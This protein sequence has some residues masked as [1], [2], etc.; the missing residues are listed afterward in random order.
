MAGKWRYFVAF[1]GALMIFQAGFSEPAFVRAQEPSPSPI[2]SPA[3]PSEPDP[4]SEPAPT[5]SPTA[6]DDGSAAPPDEQ[7]VDGSID[8]PGVERTDLRTASSR[9]FEQ[10][11]GTFVSQFFSDS[12]FYQPDGSDQWQPIDL[13]LRPTS[14]EDASLAVETAPV[15]TLLFPAVGQD[16]FL[17]IEGAGH[18]I[19]LARWDEDSAADP[20]ATQPVSQESGLFADYP[21]F[22]PGGVSLRVFPR[23]DGFKTFIVLPARPEINSFSLRLDVPGLTVVDNKDGSFSLL[24]E[25]GQVVGELPRPF[26][27][28][29]SVLETP[30]GDGRGGGVYSEAV[31]QTVVEEGESWR[32][33]LTIDPAFLESAVYPVYVD[34]TTTT[35]PTGST[36][37]SDTFANSQAPNTNFN[38]YQRPDS[39]FYH[40]QWH[41]NTPDTSYFNEVYIRFNDLE[42]TLGAGLIESAYLQMYPYWQYYH[43]D[44]RKSW[45]ERVSADWAA[46]TLKWNNRPATDLTIGEFTS[47]EDVWT[48]W[49]LKTFVQDVVNGTAPNY[50][51]MIHANSL[52]NGGWKRFVSRNDSSNLKPK[53]VVTW[54]AFAG[55]SVFYPNSATGETSTRTMQWTLPTSSAQ[56]AYEAQ[57]A[58]NSTFTTGLVTSGTVTSSI[59]A[60]HI[61][62][63]TS[64]TDGQLYYWR[65]KVKYGNNTSFTAWSD[66]GSFVYRQG[67]TLGLADHN[68]FESFALGNGDQA[69]VNVSTGNLVIS[70]PIVGLTTR[71]G[72]FDLALFYNS[73]S[74]VNAGAG[75]GWRLNAMRRL[76]ELGNGNVVFTAGDGS[77]HTFTKIST[78]GTVTTY[79]RP[80]TVYGTLRKDTANALEWTLTYRDL[81]VDSFDVFGSEGLLAKQADRHGNAITFSY[82]SGTNRLSQATDPN[83]RV[84]DFAWNTGVSPARLSSITDWAYVSSGVVQSSATGSRRQYRFFY[85]ANGQLIGWSNPVNTSGSCPTQAS[86]LTCLTYDANNGLL[87]T[88]SKTQTYTTFAVTTHPQGVLGTSS[89]T[90][91]TSIT[92]RGGEVAEIRDAEQTAASTTGTTITRT[93][94]TEVQVVRQGTPASTTTYVLVAT[95]DPHGRVQSIKRLLGATNIEQ[96]IVWDSTYPTEPASVTD[97]YG[98]LLSTPARTVSYTYVASSM[99]LVSVMTEPLT[100]STNRTTT[101]TYN[102][103]NDVTQVVVASGASS[104]TTRY[105]YTTSGCSTSATDL[106]LRSVIDNYVDGTKGGGSGNEQDVTTDYLY[107]ANGQRTRETRWNYDASGNLL[108]SRATG[109]TWDANGNQTSVIGNY[110]DGDTAD[111]Y[112][113]DPDPATGARTDLT[114]G[115]TYDTAGNQISSADPRRAL[116]SGLHADDYVTRSEFDALNRQT[117][118]TAPRDPADTSAPK[119]AT[120]TYDELGG[121]RQSTDFGGSIAASTYDRA[122]RPVKTYEDADGA[123]SGPAEITG[124][125]TYDAAGRITSQKDRNQIGNASLGTTLNVYDELSRLVDKTEAQGSSPDVSS[126]TR[127]VFDA[128]DRQIS[129]TVGY[130]DPVAQTTTTSYDLGGRATSVDDGFACTAS[131]YNFRD[132][133]ITETTGLAGTTCATDSDTQTIT[134]TYDGLGRLTR[135]AVTAGADTGDWTFDATLDGAGS[136]LTSAVKTGGV[137]STTTY[138]LSP[139]NQTS[140]ENR[141]DGS[142]NKTNYDA[143]GNPTDRCYWKSGI[144]VGECLAEGSGGWSNPPTQ[145]TTTTYDARNNR[146]EL[147]DSVL[148]T[149]TT[150]D[151]DHNYAIKAFYVKTSGGRE[152]QTLYLYDD[153]HRPTSITHQLC[154]VSSG[155][156]CSSTTATGSDSYSYDDN[157]NRTTVGESNGGTSSTHHYCYDALNRLITRKTAANCS[158]T[159]NESYTYNAAGNRTQ[160]VVG[161]VTTNFAYNAKGQL[162]KVGATTC[163]T[164]NV[165]YDTAGRTK[166]YAGWT[167]EY[168]AEGRLVK[169][170]EAGSCPGTSA[171]RVEF[172]YDGEGHRTQIKEYTAG[173]LSKTIDFI[174]QG[175]AVVQEKTNGTISRE[176]VVDDAGTVIKFCDPNCG[177]PTATYLVTWNGHG[178]AMALFKVNGDGTLTLANS[179][180]YSSW[181]APTTATHNSIADLGFRFLY[182]GAHDVQWDNFSGLALHYMH[183]RHYAPAIGRFLQPDPSG[184]EDQRYRYAGN[185][186]VSAVDP[187]GELFWFIIIVAVVG[188]AIDTH[189]YIERT[190]EPQ[191]SF[192]GWLGH[193]APGVALSFFPFGRV[194]GLFSRFFGRFIPRVAPR[195]APRVTP[196][197]TKPWWQTVRELGEA[198]ERAVRSK[199]P[200]GAKQTIYVNGRARVPDGINSV[201]R[202]ISE[203]KN[204]SYQGWTSQLQDYA[205]Y[206]ATQRPALR[207]DLYVRPSTTLSPELLRQWRLG[208]VRIRYIP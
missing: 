12:V 178:D 104:T 136:Q 127:S 100:G 191:R 58:T 72:S 115:F 159:T 170:C 11:D 111:P 51:V 76:V 93:S 112:D 61:P 62:L 67:A 37:A 198:G 151:A 16:P 81:S 5:A 164:P 99:G 128:L 137:T 74:T 39:P 33:T 110:S 176:Y 147:R 205:A 90:V 24:D 57:I 10:A 139:L 134:H 47:K 69:S 185:N 119:S 140:V 34:P 43:S 86:N 166:T 88:V 196:T 206:A 18:A 114:T 109:Y 95:T 84:V 118:A 17:R 116:G 192:G 50:G 83:G 121:V 143:A 45:V 3:T 9:T 94:T 97:N 175:D 108:D 190:P 20:V 66:T 122:A 98:A 49:D 160:M 77:V 186:P 6:D 117:K 92:Y 179:F 31:T 188:V 141:P 161:G 28:D 32:L 63:S 187:D 181:G 138:T 48:N 208:N 40:E 133:P 171:D 180:T 1:L 162:C 146:I 101:Y 80:A 2:E 201:L 172:T 96:R 42:E 14:R 53:L 21:G 38:T 157:D 78:V 167:Y 23:D 89:R 79:T 52:G 46:G 64:L 203:V 71:G 184:E 75:T 106:L 103:N 123:G 15:T 91:T 204:V 150:Y 200:I 189:D 135:S 7:P 55:P 41:G 165:T 158:G 22:L 125:S 44:W 202:T 177:S 169:A 19:S 29:S 148:G 26:M 156:S 183:A 195:I 102:A 126:T 87:A 153:R 194:G 73:Q 107:D 173:T 70:H 113:A 163:G 4:T 65:V 124:E 193:M 144:T 152:H 56:G 59:T 82:T 174:Y 68:N 197:I 27:L 207:F 25:A 120:S 60:H 30:E 105:C 168:D 129:A 199:Y 132:Y 8:P 54:S 149:A 36:T 145:V 154:V 130:G 13:T 131:A 142:V 155:H 182:V 85:D 35:F